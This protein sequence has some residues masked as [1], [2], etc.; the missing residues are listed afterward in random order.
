MEE[1]YRVDERNKKLILDWRKVPSLTCTPDEI[2][3]RLEILR[4]KAKNSFVKRSPARDAIY[5]G[6]RRY[7][8]FLGKY[9]VKTTDYS[10]TIFDCTM[11]IE[12]HPVRY[13]FNKNKN[14]KD[15]EAAVDERKGYQCWCELNDLF[16]QK[17]GT[18][19]V[20]IRS[21]FSD[22]HH[23]EEYKDIKL[24]VPKQIQ[25][26][27]HNALNRK[28]DHCYKADV[29]SAFPSS[30]VN[31][32]LPTLRGCKRVNRF[33]APTEEY[34][35]AFYIRSHHLS[36]YNEFNT[37]DDETEMHLFYHAMVYSELDRK[38]EITIL[39]KRAKSK[40]EQAMWNS[41]QEIYDRR[42]ED[43]N[44]KAL[45]VISIGYF[46]L[47]ADPFCSPLAAVTIARTNHRIFRMCNEIRSRGDSILLVA[48]DSIAWIG[49]AYEKATNQKYLGSFTYECFDNMMIVQGCKNYQYI[50]MEGRCVTK[51]AGVDRK[52]SSQ[53]RFG[54][55]PQTQVERS[56]MIMINKK[57][58][59][60]EII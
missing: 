45:S 55:I 52:T 17:R 7:N 26:A 4:D 47:N 28:F 39:C 53:W 21:A 20:T 34:P 27:P 38:N 50:N 58:G 60:V 15:Q 48:T 12:D 59:G 22:P 54:E 42:K 14:T 36:I 5:G 46:H 29:S 10:T 9:Y 51:C 11:K 40:D 49:G 56:R 6:A 43:P 13:Y 25:Y 1:Y 8:V 24:C 19:T 37:W 23:E 32:S 44:I 41:Y 35:F 3:R 33:V 2:N 18:K 30:I 16:K 31:H 57:T